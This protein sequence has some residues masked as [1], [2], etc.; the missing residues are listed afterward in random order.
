MDDYQLERL[1]TRSFEQLIQALGTEILWPQL[2]IFG[3]GPMVGAKRRLM[4]RSSIHQPRRVGTDTASC[5]QSSANNQIQRQRRMQTG[6]SS[7]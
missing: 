5:K 3:D 7:N 1:N 4:E 6:E 2:M